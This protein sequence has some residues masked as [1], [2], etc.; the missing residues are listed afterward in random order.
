MENYA[1]TPDMPVYFQNIKCLKSKYEKI[2]DTEVKELFERIIKLHNPKLPW[3]RTNKAKINFNRKDTTN[4]FYRA[5]TLEL[6]AS[7]ITIVFPK[8]KY[9]KGVILK[10]I[11]DLL[12]ECE[13]PFGYKRNEAHLSKINHWRITFDSIS[14]FNQLCKNHFFLKYFE[15]MY[16]LTS[17]NDKKYIREFGPSRCEY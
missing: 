15:V 3:I 5:F 11:E 17:D 8:P 9:G 10:I 4:K 13:F 7:I 1:V 6:S 12:S 2:K 16:H 14:S